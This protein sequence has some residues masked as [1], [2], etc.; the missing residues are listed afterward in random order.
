MGD[1]GALV[2]N[3]FSY[4]DAVIDALETSLS[5]ERMATYVGRADGDRERAVRLYTWNTAVSAAFYGP[6]QGLEVALRNGVNRELAVRYGADWYDNPGAGL[7]TGT[8]ARI[9]AARADLRRD[10]YPDDPPHMVA[11]LSFGFWVAL[12]GPGG[13]LPGFGKANYDMTIW[14]AGV[15]RAFAH[16]RLSRKAAHAPLD[17]LRTFRNRIAHH[18]PIFDRHLAAD[19]ASL[20]QV[21]GWISAE[22]RAWIMHHSRVPGVLAQSPDDADLL[23]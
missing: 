9:S 14:R 13:R 18:E 8:L 10:G 5:P 6:L 23:F 17:Y 11:A 3:A 22:T 7:D 2:K 12:L 1:P 20:L 19:Y 16:A 21:A 4:T 15:F